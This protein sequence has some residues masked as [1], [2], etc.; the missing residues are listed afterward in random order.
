M[1]KFNVTG[2]CTPEED[3]MVDISDKIVQIKKMID[4]ESYFTI[5][6]PP[7]YGKTT[8]LTTLKSALKDD[9]TVISI[10]FGQFG[11]DC[12][13]SSDKFYQE[14]VKQAA[15]SLRNSCR[16]NEYI[17]KWESYI[18]RRLSTLDDH[19]EEMCEGRKVVLMVDDAD[20]NSR[21]EVFLDFLAT[22]RQQYTERK[23]DKGSAFHSVIIASVY[24]IKNIWLT[25]PNYYA[26]WNIAADFRVD[27]SFSPVEITIMLKDY[28]AD[29]NTGMNITEISEEIYRHTSG[30]PFLVSRVCEV[31]DECLD[32][33][34]TLSGVQKAVKQILAE[35]NP[36]FDNITLNLEEDEELYKLICRVLDPDNF[37][38]FNHNYY[39]MSLAYT[40]GIIKRKGNG[41]D[42]AIIPNKIFE[43]FLYDYTVPKD[44]VIK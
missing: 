5:Q 3:Y 32:K 19:I 42:R 36:V 22:L 24:D 6:K 25:V 28:E 37:I 14:F 13:E 33:N 27:M 23:A 38:S 20:I 30:Y 1:K 17:E 26:P 4:N 35:N 29:H 43:E 7:K 44:R 34:W 41:S 11:A 12:F 39:V 16:D 18:P 15:E 31:I 8:M 9:Y 10:N 40:I 21:N 2:L